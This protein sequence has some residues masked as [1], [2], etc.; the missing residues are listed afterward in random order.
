MA[1][2][3]IFADKFPSGSNFFTTKYFIDQQCSTL[4]HDLV[5][6]NT[7]VDQNISYQ[8]VFFLVIE[9]WA[10]TCGTRNIILIHF[11]QIY[12]HESMA[13][14]CTNFVRPFYV[15][16]TYQNI[17]QSV[18]NSVRFMCVSC[19]FY[20]TWCKVRIKPDGMSSSAHS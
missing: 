12:I 8:N 3:L 7:K 14:L 13:A 2:D 18:P 16:H 19:T 15:T 11:R 1:S 4:S 20:W 9:F 6:R 17:D 10:K 5:L